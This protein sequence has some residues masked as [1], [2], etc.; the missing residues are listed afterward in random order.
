MGRERLLGARQPVG[1]GVDIGVSLGLG[2][3]ELGGLEGAPFHLPFHLRLALKQLGPNMC[4]L[5]LEEGVWGG[6]REVPQ[7][8]A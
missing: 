6:E 1:M 2:V 5:S 7:V 4:Q 3:L 8:V